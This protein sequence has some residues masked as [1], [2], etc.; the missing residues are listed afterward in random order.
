MF[1]YR[2]KIV[3]LTL[4]VIAGYGSAFYRYNHG[5][6]CGGWHGPFAHDCPMDAGPAPTKPPTLK[7]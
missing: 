2:A 5:G 7:P 4:G 1:W 6:H 3:L